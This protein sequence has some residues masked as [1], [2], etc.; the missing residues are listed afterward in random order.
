MKLNDA[1]F[2]LLLL[3]LGAA[4]LAVVQ[5]YPKIPGQQVGPGLFPGLIAVGL[6]IGG[7]L[8]IVRGWRARAVQPWFKAE[9]WVK[10]KRHLLAFVVLMGSV[11]FYMQ[12][13]TYL[14]FL[15]CAPLI[16]TALFVVLKV[17]LGRAVLVAVVASLVIHVAFYKI[18]RV[19]LPWGLLTNYS[20]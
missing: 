10:S 11:L 8:L 5:G 20:W 4:V 17:P 15:F 3:A 6:C 2:G 18:L 19:P 1:I 13:S 7:L 9:D 14:G 16:L 12:A